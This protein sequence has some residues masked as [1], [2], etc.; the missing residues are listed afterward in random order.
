MARQ[1]LLDAAIDHVTDHGLTD[2]SLRRLAAELGTSHRMLS[3]HFGSKDGLWV[4]IIKE[5]ERRQLA[6]LADLVPDPSVPLEEAMRA[7]WRHLSDPSLGPNARLFFEV[8]GQAL[9]GHAPATDLLDDVVESWV[10]P[11]AAIAESFGL[12]PGEAR[13]YARLG[14]AVTRGLLLDLLATG[15]RAGVDAAM[16]EWITYSVRRLAP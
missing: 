11:A 13:A 8:Y 15:D 6:V 1:E 10:A 5:V 14:V 4:A 16:E 3:H 2:L 12:G 7:W 9:Q